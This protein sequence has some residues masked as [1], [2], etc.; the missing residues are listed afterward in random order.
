MSY[1]KKLPE[2]KKLIEK[3][4]IDLNFIKNVGEKLIEVFIEE[5]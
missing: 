3:R 5:A 1:L 2:A 4:I